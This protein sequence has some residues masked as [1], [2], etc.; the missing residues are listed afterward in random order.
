MALVLAGDGRPVFFGH[1]RM[2]KGGRPFTC[3]KLRT[4]KRGAERWL[5]ADPQLR[6]RHARNGFKLPARE[7]PRVTPV[8]RWLRRTHIDE[9]PQL[10]NVVNGTMALV[11]PR[12]VVESELAEY[13]EE[14]AAELLGARPGIVGAWTS[15]GRRRPPYPERARLELAYLRTRSLSGD[16]RILLR[17]V[18]VVLR[19]QED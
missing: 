16:L 5:A 7:D 10:L 12:P 17:S 13:G 19:G 18:P 2:G 1:R 4:M 14:G 15:R 11:G 9:I 8:G 6:E 3:W